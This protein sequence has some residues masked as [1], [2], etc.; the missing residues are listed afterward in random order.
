[1]AL[2]VVPTVD[3]LA[4]DPTLARQ[5]PRSVCIGKLLE[6]DVLRAHLKAR[7]A[8]VAADV[9]PAPPN[10]DDDSIVTTEAAALLKIAV[11]TLLRAK[12]EEPYRSFLIP[13]G[14]KKVYRWS[15]SRIQAH[16]AK[17]P[18][19]VKRGAHQGGTTR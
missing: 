9:T 17:N 13:M 19:P 8:E 11:V 6:V 7:L 12:H 18:G 1:L 4:A 5:L 15:R 10:D 16:Q 2:T 3:Q 14:T